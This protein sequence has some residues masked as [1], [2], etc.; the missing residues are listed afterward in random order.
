MANG[1]LEWVK[2][3]GAQWCPFMTVDLTHQHFQGLRG[4]Y[5]I[6][7]G[8]QDAWTVYVGQGDIAAR[9]DAHRQEPD[10]LRFSSLGLF[11]T[12]AKVD[13]RSRNGVE[14]FLAD[15]LRPKIASRFPQVAPTAVNLPW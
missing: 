14:R 10:I 1:T 8:G 9:I 4:V 11:V 5:I 6:W 12:W 15:T 7:H 2:C 13:T 3:D